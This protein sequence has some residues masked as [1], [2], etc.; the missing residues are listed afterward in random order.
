MG[1]EAITLFLFGTLFVLIFLGVPLAFGLGAL[2]IFAGLVFWGPDSLSLLSGKITGLIFDYSLISIPFFLFM[3]T[4]LAKSGIAEDFYD[5]MY[6]WMGSLRGGLAMGTVII[7]AIIASM[8]G[9]SA[10]GVV[11]MGSI[12]LPAMLARGYD[13]NIALGTIL[14]GGALGQ[15]IPPSLL[16]IVYA[17]MANVS[18]GKMFLAGLMPGLLLTGIF[19]LYVAVRCNLN[20]ALGPPLP[21]A[22]RAAIS[23]RDK[24][25]GLRSIL[26]AML[27][28]LGV[29]GSLFAGLASPTE[30][31]AVGAFGSVVITAAYGRLNWSNFYD[32]CRVSL[33]AT[34]MVMWI[35]IASAMFVSVYSGLGGDQLVRNVL[36]QLEPSRWVVLTIFML[37]VFILGFVLDPMGILFL[38]VPVFLPIAQDLKI[39]P[40][41]LGGLLIVNLEM[42]YLTPPF[43]YN[44]FFLKSVAPPEISTADLYRAVPAF[45]AMQAIALILCMI[46]PE[47]IT[48]LPNWALG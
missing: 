32:T 13:K 11:T 43:G 47:I 25:V 8:S 38:T 27:L 34:S 48:W 41:W 28:V 16:A 22:E 7:C 45:V 5:V 2:S 18:I 6:K 30:A 42:S 4:M 44:L 33:Q 9:V 17:S 3:A 1:I 40:I 31:A 39:D 12:A 36:A 21:A 20:P 10:V 23:L 15:L 37:V 35:A 29:L 46:F 24:L 19:I 14:G 26:P